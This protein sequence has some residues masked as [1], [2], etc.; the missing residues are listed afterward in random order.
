MDEIDTCIRR[1]QCPEHYSG[2]DRKKLDVC[3]K[4]HCETSTNVDN[5]Q[6]GG[7]RGIALPQTYT[8]QKSPV[9]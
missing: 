8:C 3:A 2:S 5:T 6:G 7:R 1:L 4:F 9:R